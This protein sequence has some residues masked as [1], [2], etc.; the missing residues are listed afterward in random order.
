M[1][2]PHDDLDATLLSRLVHSF[3]HLRYVRFD[4]SGTILEANDALADDLQATATELRGRSIL[5]FL[6][7]D[8]AAD[9]GGWIGA[10]DLPQEAVVL[11]F[12]SGRTVPVSLRCVFGRR[13]G[14]YV[15]FGEP[16]AG[17]EMR[18]SERMLQLNN[19]LA[20]LSRENVRR[21]RELE[22]ALE[23]LE[24]THWH[25]RKIQ[26]NLPICMGC[27]KVRTG[28]ASWQSI[29]DYFREN[30]I[31]LSHGYCPDCAE[32]FAREHGLE[33]GDEP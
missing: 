4:V 28:A 1:P 20:V 18:A 8:D 3:E 5:D 11:N 29:V 15:L 26:E 9:V 10:R 13:E 24:T 7:E 16:L 6:P 22:R 32:A 23:E 2:E 25:L 12:A 21:R 27:G 19:E 30:E 14:G 17:V 31:F 33:A